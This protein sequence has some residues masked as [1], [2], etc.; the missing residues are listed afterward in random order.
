MFVLDASVTLGW[1]F[2]DE[3][4]PQL[5]ELLESLTTGAAWVPVH[6]SLEVANA[7]QVAQRCGRLTR[8]PTELL[9]PLAKLRIRMDSESFTRAHDATL[10]LAGK[11]GLTAYDAAYLE[12]A[13][14]RGL[15]LATADKG[16]R[17]AAE[18][19]AIQVL[20]A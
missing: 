2:E 9:G 14:R 13:K 4:T 16:L 18:K 3:A 8:S 7:V 6:W 1:L 11:H 17:R 10:E 12:L 20:P 5:L 15:P 19:A